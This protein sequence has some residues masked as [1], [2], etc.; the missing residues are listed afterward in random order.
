[1]G[2]K[3][4]LGGL[5][6]FAALVGGV[7]AA[8][9][10]LYKYEKFSEE[11]DQ[12]FTDVLESAS[13]VKDSAKRSYTTLKNSQTK[14]DFKTAAKDIGVAAKN[15]AVDAKNLAVDASKD[16]YKTVKEALDEKLSGAAEEDDVVDENVEHIS[17]PYVDDEDAKSDAEE[18]KDEAAEKAEDTDIESEDDGDVEV[19]FFTTDADDADA[20]TEVTGKDAEPTAEEPAKDETAADATKAAVDAA[21]E[22]K[23]EAEEAEATATITEE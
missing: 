17:Y 20:K 11:V 4:G 18:V 13:E 5:V 16:A 15:L 10:Y 22:V 9:S 8:V 12:D 21:T 2:K 23:Q 19:E 14:E 3:K 7:A 1:M 6:G